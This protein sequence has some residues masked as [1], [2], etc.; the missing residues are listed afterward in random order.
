MVCC[1]ESRCKPYAEMCHSPVDIMSISE[2]EVLQA[3]KTTDA[4]RI[5]EEFGGGFMASVEVNHQLHC[6]VISHIAL[7]REQ[8]HG[9]HGARTS[10]A[11]VSTGTTMQL[12]PSSS[13]TL[14][15][16]LLH[17]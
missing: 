3:G 16:W 2:E 14:L 5:P 9:L 13:L 6:V 10:S 11:K 12:G 8:S 17:I 1:A 7:S 15:R 4:I